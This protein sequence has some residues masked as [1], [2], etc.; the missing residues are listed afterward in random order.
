MMSSISYTGERSVH[1]FLHFLENCRRIAVANNM[2]FIWICQLCISFQF[3]LIGFNLAGRQWNWRT[4]AGR[5]LR[6]STRGNLDHHFP[7]LVDVFEVEKKHSMVSSSLQLV[8][9]AA[10][11]HYFYHGTS[12]FAVLWIERC[13]V[14]FL[15]RMRMGTTATRRIVS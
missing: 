14:F 10:R 4:A 1:F 15:L 12:A 7:F 11:H 2:L 5:W 6:E 13:L 8:L 3:L 9:Y